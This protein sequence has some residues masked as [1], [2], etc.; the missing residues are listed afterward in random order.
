MPSSISTVRPGRLPSSSTLRLPRRFAIE[1]SSTTVT[2]GA[3]TRSPMRPEKAESPLRLKSPSRP[4]PTA[5]CSRIPGQPGAS[6]TGIGPAGAGTASSSVTAMRA[7]SLAKYSGDFSAKNS[8]PSRP[9][10]PALPSRR[11]PLS[12]AMALTRIENS[13]C[14]SST[15]TPSELAIRTRRV[16]SPRLANTF[17]IRGSCARAA[18]S[19]RSTSAIRSAS[20]STPTLVSP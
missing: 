4:W 18:R 11:T 17:S 9:P 15:S 5:S 7:A 8:G 19:A 14:T 1:P 12:L 16:C 20:G 3:A 13:G 2:P 10:P 6:T